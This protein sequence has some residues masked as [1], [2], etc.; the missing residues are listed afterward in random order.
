VLDL[1]VGDRILLGS[2]PGSPVS[3]RCGEVELFDAQ[4][5]RR[6]SRLAVRIEK[7]RQIPLLTEEGRAP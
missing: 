5:G 3:L 1:K 6:E 2:P 4:L 7:V